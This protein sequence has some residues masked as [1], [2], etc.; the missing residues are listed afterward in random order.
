[1]PFPIR[2][3]DVMSSPA[4]TTTPETTAAD[5]A[6]ECHTEG[7]GSLVVVDGG[8]IVG[9][10]TSDDFVGL[11][12]TDPDAR[13]R[14]VEAFMSAPVVTITA[15][16]PVG[17]AVEQMRAADVARLVVVEDGDPVGVVT[18]DDVLRHVPQ[19]FHRSQFES[20][21]GERRYRVTRETAYEDADWDAEC[22][23]HA[24]DAVTVGDRV[25]F[26]KPITESDVRAFASVS[27]DTN[28]LHLDADYAAE[29]RFGRRIVH[30]TLV[31]GLISAALA[32]LPGLTI[33][34]SQNLS[35]L[36]PVE[37]GERVTAV[38]EVVEN[39]DHNKYQLTTDVV[40]EDGETVIEG[41]A[42]VLV[43][44]A[45]VEDVVAVEAL[46]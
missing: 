26:S 44:E 38:C 32:R 35:F 17:G 31:S 34:L 4:R 10:V 1:M 23:C 21:P 16:A 43:D 15:D 24:E 3:A 18:S 19:V 37:I 7:I 42:A 39:F 33:Y 29:T 6:A 41:Q 30:G 20:P 40:D 28:R 8:E 13:T 14:R 25:T 11:L 36:A 9:I 46:A 5:A 12:G 2:T 45:P 27:G 22:V